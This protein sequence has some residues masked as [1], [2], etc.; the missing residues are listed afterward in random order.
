MTR[1]SPWALLSQLPSYL[2]LLINL[3]GR[4]PLGPPAAG[5]G[6]GTKLRGLVG[7]LLPHKAAAWFCC[8][9]FHGRGTPCD[10][11]LDSALLGG[12]T[13]INSSS[14]PPGIILDLQSLRRRS[15]GSFTVRPKSAAFMKI[16]PSEL[17]PPTR[18][19]RG[20]AA[21]PPL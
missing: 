10:E 20:T 15:L 13:T 14:P 19:T 6:D 3:W 7:V 9:R 16:G 17:P 11:I 8:G 12:G 1:V 5:W 21:F 4:R 2:R 18:A